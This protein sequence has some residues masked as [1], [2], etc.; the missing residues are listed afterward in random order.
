MHYRG[1]LCSTAG[2]GRWSSAHFRDF[3]EAG[4]SQWQCTKSAQRKEKESAAAAAAAA[5]PSRAPF[6][7][8]SRTDFEKVQ[9][10]QEPEVIRASISGG[11]PHLMD[12]HT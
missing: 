11:S 9:P 12:G 5:Y 4:S 2:L 7:L 8:E 1:M 6:A 3:R 10:Q